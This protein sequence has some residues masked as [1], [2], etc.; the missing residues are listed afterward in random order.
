MRG[1]PPAEASHRHPSRA[2]EETRPVLATGTGSGV[3]AL[4]TRSAQRQT[5]PMMTRGV[6]VVT[7]MPARL[8]VPGGT[9][10]MRV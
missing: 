5:M 7:G 4:F 10:E 1:C 2:G 6:V 3:L 8:P 9:G